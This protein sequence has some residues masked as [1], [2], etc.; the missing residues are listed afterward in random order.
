VAGL[1]AFLLVPAA[2]R[3][4]RWRVRR[5]LAAVL[6]IVLSLGGTIALGW[7]ALGQVYNL[8]IDLPQYQ[9]NVTEKLD[10]L[11]LNLTGKLGNTL[12]MLTS[13]SKQIKSGGTANSPIPRVVPRQ[14]VASRVGTMQASSANNMSQPV[15]VQI[16]EP[17][18]S[19]TAVAERTMIPLVH[20]LTTAFIVVIFLVFMLLGRE[21]I[22]G[23]GLRLA[24]SEQIYA[25]TTAIDDA[26]A[27]VSRYLQMQLVV[28][29]CYGT[30]SGLL[31][32]WI[33][34]PHPLLWA[35]L[36]CLLRFVP[37]IGILMAAIGPLLLFVR[38]FTALGHARLDCDDVCR[39]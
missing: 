27:R 37:Y 2:T 12:A 26:S 19:M 23:R 4:E 1:L 9:Q 5:T 6:V 28:N 7:V 29:L 3:L 39:S 8:A 11:H 34:V 36:T 18:A 15:A 16:E 25:T 31:L 21:D 20:P 10:S 17:E 35:V 14:R 30:V 13:L 22:L 38:C 32:R 33:G 24:G